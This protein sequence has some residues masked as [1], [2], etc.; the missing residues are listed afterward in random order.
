V[1]WRKLS[2]PLVRR[3]EQRVNEFAYP[4]ESR[5]YLNEP[6]KLSTSDFFQVLAKRKSRRE[7]GPLPISKLEAV[8]W[9]GS[10]TI[11]KSSPKSERWERRTAPSAGGKHPCDLFIINRGPQGHT[12]QLYEPTPHA[13]ANLKVNVDLLE[14]LVARIDQCLR[15]DNATVLLLGA[16]YQRSVSKYKNAESL[17]W[18]DAGALVATLSLVAE[19]FSLNCCAFG[20]TGEPQFSRL[21]QTNLVFGAGGVLLGTRPKKRS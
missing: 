3:R 20:L 11:E 18:R 14:E 12:L 21:L 8:L 2:D 16:Q 7:F 17:V 10:R 13:L 15:I 5:T 9:Y 1:S 6:P 19:A 4:V